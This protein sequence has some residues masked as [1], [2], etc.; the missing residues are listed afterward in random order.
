ML[1]TYLTRVFAQLSILKHSPC[2][3]KVGKLQEEPCLAQLTNSRKSIL[4]RSVATWHGFTT[5]GCK[6]QYGS[7]S[8]II[9]YSARKFLLCSSGH[10]HDAMQS[11]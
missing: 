6:L 7:L 2:N 5:R 8:S 4:A 1:V 9:S 11:D 3:K 10:I